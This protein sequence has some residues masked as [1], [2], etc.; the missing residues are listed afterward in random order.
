MSRF[1]KRLLFRSR[2]PCVGSGMITSSS[3]LSLNLGQPEQEFGLSGES[4]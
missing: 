4:P 1:P 3:A 2:L